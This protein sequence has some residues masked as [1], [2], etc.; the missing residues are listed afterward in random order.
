V[1]VF[2][3]LCCGDGCDGDGVD[4]EDYVDGVDCDALMQ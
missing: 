2:Y 4:D 1:A 3:S